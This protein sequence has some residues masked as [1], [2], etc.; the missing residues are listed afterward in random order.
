MQKQKIQL[1]D[2]ADNGLRIKI[3]SSGLAEFTKRN[4]PSDE[5]VEEF[6]E[7]VEEEAKE[8]EIE[9]SLNEI[10]QDENGKMVDVKKLTILKKHGFF[11]WFFSILIIG[12]LITGAAFYLY[13]YVY[14]QSGSDAEAVEFVIEGKNDLTAGEEFFYTLR[15]KN[16][17]NIA[18]RNIKFTLNYP[19]NF[20]Y[21]DSFPLPSQEK[22]SVWD[23]DV[24]APYASGSIKIKGMMIG[25]EEQTGVI[26]GNMTYTPENFSSEFK[27]NATLTSTIRNIGLNIEIDYLKTA[28]IGDESE[29]IVRYS[30]RDNNFIKNFRVSFEPQDNFDIIEWNG[31]KLSVDKG[32][33]TSIRPG[34]WQVDEVLPE[35]K[36]LPIKLKFNKKISDKQELKMLFEY[37]V[38]NS[39]HIVFHEESLSF[40]VLKSDL[41]LSLI[42]N[43]S[44]ND[45]GVDFG[46][47]L[48]YSIVYNNKGD[49]ELNDVVIMAVLESEFLDRASL[50][51]SLKGSEKGNTI[52]WTKAEIPALEKI[53]Q[54]QEGTIDF[55]INVLDFKSIS[56]KKGFEIKSYAQYSVGAKEDGTISK[57]EDNKSNTIVNK[58]NSDLTLSEAIRYFD[59][60]NIPVGTGPHPPKAGETTSYKV[61]WNISNNLHELND[62]KAVV[63]LPEKITWNGKERTTAGAVSYDSET[64]SIIWK[65]GR[66]PITVYQAS[67]EFS[68]SVSP[69]DEDRNKIMVLLPGTKVTAIDAETQAELQVDTKA[70][71]S[72]LEDDEIAG[73]DGIVE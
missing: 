10:Y 41:N 57:N 48:N 26:S 28:L 11:F 46:E 63:K 71:T 72:K 16:D 61:Y 5:E 68:I 70:K 36:I 69:T 24:L 59:Q 38:N 17:S 27:K 13:K 56:A 32:T 45:Q 1:N 7:F 54:D 60:E 35:K 30:A 65:V 62:L 37:S 19:D 31:D 15:Y 34:V 18:I 55:S 9:E 14:L 42:V 39:D 52:T 20:I 73:G 3:E 43:G 64:N 51:D 66:L 21:L 2:D 23:L 8:E 53:T 25:K 4:L 67:A 40:E 50:N 12:G 22:N 47:T 58:I 44:R 33:F 29:I 49:S 6:E